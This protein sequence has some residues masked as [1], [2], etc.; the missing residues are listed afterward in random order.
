MHTNRLCDNRVHFVR[1]WKKY[2]SRVIQCLS[3]LHSHESP[4][5]T[6]DGLLP[7]PDRQLRGI[8][9]IPAAAVRGS[10]GGDGAPAPAPAGGQRALGDRCQGFGQQRGFGGESGRGK[11]QRQ[12]G[13]PV[14]QALQEVLRMFAGPRQAATPG[15]PAGRQRNLAPAAAAGKST[16]LMS[17]GLFGTLFMLFTVR[18]SFFLFSN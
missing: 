17:P 1:R 16:R 7:H 3:V 13:T 12:G 11:G 6:P 14:H 4:A 5:Q 15:G 18:I 2:S 10:R 9:E 8:G